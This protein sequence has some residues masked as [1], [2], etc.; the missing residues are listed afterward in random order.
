MAGWIGFRLD[1]RASNQ[2]SSPCPL[3]PVH[4]GTQDRQA[5]GTARALPARKDRERASLLSLAEERDAR[6]KE[7]ARPSLDG[8]VTRHIPH[9]THG[10][11]TLQKP[12]PRLSPGREAGRQNQVAVKTLASDGPD[13]RT[14]LP[15][16]MAAPTPRVG[17]PALQGGEDVKT[18]FPNGPETRG[19]PGQRPPERSMDRGRD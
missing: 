13:P 11:R 1:V 14:V 2:N 10:V 12:S 4:C 15:G 18:Q 17:I 16:A 19:T 6:P 3:V 7:I 9:G 8:R 5:D